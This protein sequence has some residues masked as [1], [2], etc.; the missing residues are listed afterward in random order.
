MRILQITVVLGTLL[1]AGASANL[2]FGDLNK[3]PETQARDKLEA[4]V[5]SLEPDARAGRSGAQF[6]LAEVLRRAP[7]SARDP[8]LARYWYKKAAEQGQIA[9]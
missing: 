9:A 6:R 2:F 4:Q 7:E 8:G 5:A 1:L 3:D